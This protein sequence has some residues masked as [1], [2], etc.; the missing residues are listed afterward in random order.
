MTLVEGARGEEEGIRRAIGIVRRAVAEGQRPKAI[1]RERWSVGGVQGAAGLELALTGEVC[2]VE[3][4][5]ATVAEIADE[6]VIAEAPE[7]SGR[8][9]Q[10]PRRVEL[11]LRRDAAEQVAGGVEGV[12]EAVTLAC[13]VV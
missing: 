1:D 13:H 9:C 6:Q 8:E 12:H 2:R 11:T 7:I 3:G 5:D 10:S 4:V